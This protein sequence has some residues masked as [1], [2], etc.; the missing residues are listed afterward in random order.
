M[1]SVKPAMLLLLAAILLVGLTRQV[2]TPVHVTVVI[3]TA[4]P[5]VNQ[6]VSF[7]GTDSSGNGVHGATY[8]YNGGTCG[9]GGAL[10]DGLYWVTTDASGDYS[11]AFPASDFPT[12]GTYSVYG[13]DT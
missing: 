11:G 4:N 13:R 5:T 1:A 2:F 8:L 3:T 12:A 10:V 7:S 9:L 6:P